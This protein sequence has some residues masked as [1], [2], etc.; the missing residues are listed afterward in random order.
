MLVLLPWETVI[1]K[2]LLWFISQRWS[3]LL[4]KD[5]STLSVE[6]LP[7]L[8]LQDKKSELWVLTINPEKKMMSIK[9]TLL[10]LFWW[11]VEQLNLFQMFHVATLLPLQV[12][13]NILS[14]PELLLALTTQN[15][16]LLDLW[17]IQFPQSS[18][19][20]LNQRT[21]PIYQNLLMVLKSFLN[22]IL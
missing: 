5:D 20:L 2:A 6:F 18:E 9:R 21:L 8:L 12:L 16:I 11:W 14:K 19:S 3:L 22:L 1:Q 10:E 17:N 15:L 7:E 4:I 13:I